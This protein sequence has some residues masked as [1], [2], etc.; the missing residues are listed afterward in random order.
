MG[1]LGSCFPSVSTKLIKLVLNSKET[2]E[3]KAS[4]VLWGLLRQKRRY[5]WRRNWERREGRKTIIKCSLSLSLCPGVMWHQ[6]EQYRKKRVMP[7]TKKSLGLTKGLQ[8]IIWFY[9]VWDWDLWYGHS[10]FL[11]LKCHYYEVHLFFWAQKKYRG[12]FTTKITQQK[13]ILLHIF[14]YEIEKT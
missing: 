8:K 11:H 7:K 10:F 13:M 2:S 6:A 1:R 9:I 5:L 12:W 3:R 14:N 4:G